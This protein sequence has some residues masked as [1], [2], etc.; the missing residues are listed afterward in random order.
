MTTTL[1]DKANERAPPGLWGTWRRSSPDRG[2]P[3]AG[4]YAA[5]GMTA[6]FK[7]WHNSNVYARHL[8]DIRSYRFWMIAIRA[9]LTARQ[10]AR[11]LLVRGLSRR[12]DGADGV[13]GLSRPR[14]SPYANVLLKARGEIR[15]A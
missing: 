9:A 4:F 7:S 2:G 10:D 14:Q 11:A 15:R 13:I 12:P 8:C 1:A 5:T 3:A 6:P